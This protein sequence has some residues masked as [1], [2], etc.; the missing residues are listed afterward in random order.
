MVL[1]KDNGPSV[2][3]SAPTRPDPEGTQSE[4][5]EALW[6]QVVLL[7]ERLSRLERDLAL[8]DEMIALLKERQ[9][10]PM[11]PAESPPGYHKCGRFGCPTMIPLARLYCCR[12][13]AAQQRWKIRKPQGGV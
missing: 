10:A 9:A 1:R 5:E 6:C 3:P 11:P 13:H 2:A 8:R 7:R 12:T 4:R